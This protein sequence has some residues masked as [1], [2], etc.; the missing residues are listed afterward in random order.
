MSPLVYVM[1]PSGAGKDTILRLARQELRRGEKI[2]FAHRYITRE[3][4]P[5]HENYI[6][7]SPD[8]F[9]TRRASGLLAFDWQVYG[10]RYGVGTEIETWR[11]EGFVVVVSGSREHFRAWRRPPERVLPVLISVPRDL[12]AQRLASRGRE[13]AVSRS[14]RLQRAEEFVLTDPALVEIDNSAPPPNARLPCCWNCCEEVAPIGAVLRR[15]HGRQ[16]DSDQG[17]LGR[18]VP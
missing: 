14:V 6:A 5:R 4:D 17:R 9:E 8:E 10:F 12:L 2:A 13:D 7:L 3:A 16:V 18:V 11:R 1:G 15:C